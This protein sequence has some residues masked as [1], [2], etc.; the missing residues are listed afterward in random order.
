MYGW[1]IDKEKNAFIL[2]GYSGQATSEP[3]SVVITIT[4]LDDIEYEIES[5]ELS[6]PMTIEW[7]IMPRYL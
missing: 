5:E 1:H 6:V 7:K 4:K 3:Q 2:A